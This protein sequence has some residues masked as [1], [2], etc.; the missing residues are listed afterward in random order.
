MGPACSPRPA[1]AAWSTWPPDLRCRPTGR[2]PTAPP[3]RRPAPRRGGG[4]RRR[5]PTASRPARSAR[6][7]DDERTSPL[8]TT[9]GTYVGAL[10]T[11]ELPD[12]SPAL[13]LPWIITF[14]PLGDD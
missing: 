14:G 10:V 6:N 4:G 13:S 9:K 3:H 1:S 5:M 2:P 7:R 12:D 11:L 8:Q